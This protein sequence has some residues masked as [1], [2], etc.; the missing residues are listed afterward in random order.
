M[1]LRPV[2]HLRDGRAIRVLD[3]LVAVR[4]DLGDG[5]VHI[6]LSHTNSER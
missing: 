1:H 2:T 6:N 3:D 4:V 5:P